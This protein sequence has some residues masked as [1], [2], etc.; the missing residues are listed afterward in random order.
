MYTGQIDIVIYT[1]CQH[2]LLLSL[3]ADTQL[4]SFGAQQECATEWLF[5]RLHLPHNDYCVTVLSFLDIL[6]QQIAESY[7]IAR[8][9]LSSE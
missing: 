2:I 9:S 6:L 7:L 4:S 8:A 1:H 3:K 5:L